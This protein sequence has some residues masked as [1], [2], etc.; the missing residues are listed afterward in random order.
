MNPQQMGGVSKSSFGFPQINLSSW[1]GTT[2]GKFLSRILISFL[3]LGFLAFVLHKWFN[4]RLMEDASYQPNCPTWLMGSP[5]P[6]T[7]SLGKKVKKEEESDSE[8]EEEHFEDKEEEKPKPKAKPVQKKKKENF[9]VLGKPRPDEQGG[10]DL[11][12]YTQFRSSYGP[13]EIPHEYAT[14]L[15]TNPDNR[16]TCDF[17]KNLDAEPRPIRKLMRANDRQDVIPLSTQYPMFENFVPQ[18]M[19]S[20]ESYG[21]YAPVHF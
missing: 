19:P 1:F 13:K 6:G 4:R 14:C 9:A 18:A 5:I 7:C 11:Q 15:T 2:D 17:W 12:S 20:M 21:N 8:D 16:Q 10:R 3:I